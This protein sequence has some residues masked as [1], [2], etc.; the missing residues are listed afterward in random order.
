[1]SELRIEGLGFKNQGPYSLTITSG[2]CIC[3]TGSS[4]SGKSLLLRCIADLDE[5]K[6][7]VYL[8]DMAAHSMPAVK[9]RKKIGMLPS[10]SSWWLD[11]VGDHFAGEAGRILPKL[12]F[13][14]DVLNWQV[15][16]LSTGEKQR[17]AIARLLVQNPKV[18]LLDEPTAS[19]DQD[20][21]NLVESLVNEY[22]KAH[23]TPV[24]WVSHDPNQV[25]R[26][27]DKHYQLHPNQLK[28]SPETLT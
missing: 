7:T 25:K 17:L 9:W 11:T 13:T 4:G 3:I 10:E 1:M 12:G 6:G 23:R 24:L 19:L 26:V 27:A 8:D 21:V 22:Q 5:H 2:Q 14:A 28:E 18:L 20:N 16:R 15:K